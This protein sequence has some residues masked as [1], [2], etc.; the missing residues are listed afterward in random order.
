MDIV[1]DGDD[2][3]EVVLLGMLE[4]TTTIRTKMKKKN[5]LNLRDRWTAK[6]V[7]NM[8]MSDNNIIMLYRNRKLKKYSVQLYLILKV[9]D[10]TRL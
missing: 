2:F 6:N 8:I 7:A 1:W 3:S 5:N 9:Y 10:S 4:D